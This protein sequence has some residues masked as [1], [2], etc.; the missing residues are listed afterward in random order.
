MVVKIL[1]S[2]KAILKEA[3]RQ[4]KVGQNV[5]IGV[6]PPKAKSGDRPKLKVGRDIPTKDEMRNILRAAEGSRWYAVLS[7]AALVGL[8]SSELRGLMWSDIDLKQGTVHVQRRADENN[9][10][11]PPKSEAGD[12]VIQV[13]SLLIN[14]LKRWKL[15]CPKGELDLCFPTGIGTVESHANIANRGWYRFQRELGTVSAD[16]RAPATVPIALE[17]HD[18]TLPATS[19]LPVTFGFSANAVAKQHP[20]LSP[21]AQAQLI[22]RYEVLALRHRLSLHGGQMEPPTM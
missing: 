19:S 3:M 9:Q 21:A 22:E 17:V 8:R 6:K 1:V 11:G 15:A 14:I 12:R 2:T 5:A 16:G 20:G 10:M 13:S 4:G 18:F 7:T